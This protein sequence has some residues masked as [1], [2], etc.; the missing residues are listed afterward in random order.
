[1]SAFLATTLL[2]GGGALG[3]QEPGIPGTGGI[4]STVGWCAAF[5]VGGLEFDSQV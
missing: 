4:I 1:M 5:R 3:C 2:G